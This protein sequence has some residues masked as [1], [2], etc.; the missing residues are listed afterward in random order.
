MT[1]DKASRRKTERWL[2][3]RLQRRLD[4]WNPAWRRRVG[5]AASEERIERRRRGCPFSD[6][7]IFEGLLLAILSANTQWSTVERIR[8]ELADPF[9]G[10]SLAAYARRNDGE[11]V[12]LLPWFSERK[13]GSTGLRAGLLRLREAAATL[14][15]YSRAHGSADAFFKEA[16][17]DAGGEPEDLAVAIG[18]S[19][20]WKLPGLGI[21][22]AAEALRNI[23]FDLCKPDRHV[24]RAM[25][26]W[27]LVEYASWPEVS[28]FTAPKASPPEL[29]RTMCAVRALAGSN[30][31][32]A[33]YATSVIWIAGAASGA[34]LSNAELSSIASNDRH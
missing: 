7:E 34:R 12:S 11:I 6:D 28:A 10:F 23:G 26:A 13:A 22:L 15:S 31:V 5:G 30:G 16:L 1:H 18:S 29:H 17:R 2:W 24:L 9:A 20:R 8:P 4:E 19:K 3:D 33:S 32:G 27:Q 14:A 25:G 21:A